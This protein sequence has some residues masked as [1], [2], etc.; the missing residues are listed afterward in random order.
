LRISSRGDKAGLSGG[1]MATD[2]DAG[3]SGGAAAAA[4]AHPKRRRDA[5]GKGHEKTRAQSEQIH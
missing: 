4:A 2:A 3:G 5:H 1:E